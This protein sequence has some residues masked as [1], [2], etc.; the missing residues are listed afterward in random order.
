MLHVRVPIEA[1]HQRIPPHQVEDGVNDDRIGGSVLALSEAVSGRLYNSS[2]NMCRNDMEQFT[3]VIAHSC[4]NQP[5]EQLF[6]ETHFLFRL[7]LSRGKYAYT[8]IYKSK[9]RLISIA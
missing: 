3:Q 4:G 9:T 8:A 6:A 2:K 5:H 1:Y 7:H